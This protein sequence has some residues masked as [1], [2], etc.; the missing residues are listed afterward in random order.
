VFEGE[1]EEEEENVDSNGVEGEDWLEV[2]M[3][4]ENPPDLSP[5]R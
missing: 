5:R 2:G 1:E 4:N 3:V